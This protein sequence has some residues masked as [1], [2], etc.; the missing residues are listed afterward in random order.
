MNKFFVVINETTK[1]S[2]S[3]WV[4]S[5]IADKATIYYDNNCLKKVF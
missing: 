5:D 3:D 4:W 2:W 1:N